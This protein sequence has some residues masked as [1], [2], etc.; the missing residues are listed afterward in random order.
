MSDYGELIDQSTVK[1]ERLLPG[2][3]ERVWSYLTQNDKRARWLCGGDVET[4]VG[5]HVDMHFHNASLSSAE[6]IPRPAKYKDMPEKI[7]F[8][9]EV[10]RCDPPH[11]LT[12]TWVFEGQASEVCYELT[13]QGDK[14]LLI[15]THRRLQSTDFVLSVSGG[16]HTHLDILV[17]V[18]EGRAPGPFWK[19]H[20]KFEAEYRQRLGV[21]D[22]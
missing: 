6:D 7:S 2:P 15:L 14:V 18:L 3:I 11:M 21:T 17:T 20:T 19:S 13:E 1:F 9:G 5:G 22:S 12:H 4:S 10:T 16:W 8:V